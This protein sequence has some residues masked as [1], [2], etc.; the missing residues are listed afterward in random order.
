MTEQ[1]LVRM[2]VT[3]HFSLILDAEDGSTPKTWKLCPTYRAIA[4]IEETIHKD[5]KKFEDWKDLSSG[6]EF[7]VIIWG[8]LDK[9]NPEVSL[10]DVIDVL[11]PEVQRLLSDVIFDL[12]FPGVKEAYVKLLAAKESGETA[13][14]NAETGTTM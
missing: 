11:N 5:I 1:S 10:D 6:K 7:P 2:R 8:M 12:M 3:P 9:F 14:P 4:K 13:N